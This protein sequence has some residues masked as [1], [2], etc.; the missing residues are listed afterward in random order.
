MEWPTLGSMTA[1]KSVRNH[2]IVVR[3]FVNRP[4]GQQEATT[5]GI[6]ATSNRCMRSAFHK[7]QW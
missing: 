6:N 1:K 4:P 5:E 7:V 2:N 3:Y